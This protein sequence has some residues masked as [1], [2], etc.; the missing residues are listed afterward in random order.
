MQNTDN[1]LILVDGSSYLFRAYHGLPKLTS[2]SGEPTGAIKGV[3]SMIQKLH[4][5]YQPSHI[6]IVFDAPGKTFR[7]DIY[8]E[9]KA[10]RPPI[11]DELRVQIKPLLELIE[12]ML[13][14]H[15]Q[16]K[17]LKIICRC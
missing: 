10:H 7:S 17:Q 6:A 2:R 11:D 16:K 8:A 13:S 4:D 12:S 3:I 1:Q 15:W 5:D 9:Y 14:E